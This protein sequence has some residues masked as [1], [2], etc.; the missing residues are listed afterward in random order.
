[1]R[2]PALDGTLFL[3]GDAERYAFGKIYI[4]NMTVKG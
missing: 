3:D 4:V 2:G 1:V